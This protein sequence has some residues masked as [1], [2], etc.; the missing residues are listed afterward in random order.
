MHILVHSTGLIG[1]SIH[2][3]ATSLPCLALP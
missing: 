3:K 2:V 1:I